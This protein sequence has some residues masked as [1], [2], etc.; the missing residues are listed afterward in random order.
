MLG[1]SWTF[2][3]K[4][5]IFP[6]G[7][8]WRKSDPFF[9]SFST[10]FLVGHNQ[11]TG[12][13]G[14]NG[15]YTQPV[16]RGWKWL[17]FDQKGFSGILYPFCKIMQPSVCW[18]WG[19]FWSFLQKG[20]IFPGGEPPG[21]KVSFFIHFR[22]VFWL[23]IIKYPRYR[24]KMRRYARPDYWGWKLVDFDQKVFFWEFCTLFTK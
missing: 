15:G 22:P 8:P 11:F 14:K 4:Y 18:C 12:V 5:P 21:E 7:G 2:L 20:P 9:H 6:G 19:R 17:N 16:P 23:F 13:T 1:S 10:C 3:Q 24:S